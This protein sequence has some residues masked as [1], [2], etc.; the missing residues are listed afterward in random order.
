MEYQAKDSTMRAAAAEACD[1]DRKVCM[2][3]PKPAC[4]VHTSCQSSAS[5]R[6]QDTEEFDWV[7]AAH[8]CIRKVG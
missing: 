2:S 5:K 3:M 7:Q 6:D 4:T 8:H 1:A